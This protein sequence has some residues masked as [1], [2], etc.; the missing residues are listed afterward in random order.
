LYIPVPKQA[1]GGRAVI[2]FSII[3][4][5]QPENPYSYFLHGQSEP[6]KAIV[7]GGDLRTIETIRS[8]WQLTLDALAAEPAA[9]WLNL[10]K[11]TFADTKLA[12]C[13]IAILRRAQEHDT[14]VYIVGSDSVQD[15]L[16][17]CKVP[18]LQ[19]FT[20]VA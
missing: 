20:K 15:I 6:T 11:V 10:T 1:P 16:K 12:A 9:I 4:G 8:F 19:L 13:L 2:A 7:V 18:P 14:D 5:T 17:L 3:G